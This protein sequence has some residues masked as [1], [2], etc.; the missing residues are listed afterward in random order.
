VS[1]DDWCSPP[2]VADRLVD[3][4]HGPVDVD[5]CSNAR[6]F[7]QALLAYRTGG[8]IL[9]W[10]LAVPVDRTVYQNDPYSQAQPWTDKAL[11]EI[12]IGNVR[13]LVRLS[14]MATSTAWWADMC[15]RPARNPRVLALKRLYFLD[16]EAQEAGQRRWTCRFEPALTY[17]GHRPAQFT[18]AF[19]SLTRWSTWGRS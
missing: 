10:R 6:S 19:A 5:P 12:A 11:A 1:T 15:L 16:P 9:P 3:L 18:R 4:F 17:I 2:E 8:L 13:E 14:M 7:I